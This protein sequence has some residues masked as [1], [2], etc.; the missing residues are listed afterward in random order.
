V[1]EVDIAILNPIYRECI[2]ITNEYNYPWVFKEDSGSYETMIE[3]LASL[4]TIGRAVHPPHS[5]NW[6]AMKRNGSIPICPDI[7]DYKNKIIIEYEEES[8]AGKRMG[9]YGKKGHW[10]ESKRDFRRDALY[11]ENG[12]RFCKI[13]ESERKA[14]MISKKLFHFLADCYCKRDTEMYLDM[15]LN[16]KELKKA[17]KLR[18]T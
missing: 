8:T 5:E 1:G 3:F 2:D 16:D 15:Y 11:K 4:S 6:D 7:M 18:K 12:F 17:L 13:W 10:A 9:K 14:D